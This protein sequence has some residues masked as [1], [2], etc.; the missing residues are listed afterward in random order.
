MILHSVSSDLIDMEGTEPVVDTEEYLFTVP[1]VPVEQNLVP[2]RSV[3]T[4]EYLVPVVQPV[5]RVGEVQLMLLGLGKVARSVAVAGARHN[6]LV[7]ASY[8]IISFY[9]DLEGIN[10]N[11]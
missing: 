4:P 7:A 9:R 10:I 6:L 8:M 3:E 2:D 11:F 5:G 1:A